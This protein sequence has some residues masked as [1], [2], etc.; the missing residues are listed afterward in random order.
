MKKRSGNG[1]ERMSK[2]A[3]KRRWMESQR[4]KKQWKFIQRLEGRRKEERIMVRKGHKIGKETMVCVIRDE[5]ERGK[6]SVMHH[7]AIYI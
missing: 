3:C 1:G 5:K 7:F 4:G 6:K 2:M